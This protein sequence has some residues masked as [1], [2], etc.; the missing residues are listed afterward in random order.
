M[1]YRTINDS[2][3]GTDFNPTLSPV[4]SKDPNTHHFHPQ[5]SCG[6]QFSCCVAFGPLLTPCY[7]SLYRVDLT[8]L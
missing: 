2:F 3:L 8:Y 1:I 7:V 6:V 4:Y 5:L